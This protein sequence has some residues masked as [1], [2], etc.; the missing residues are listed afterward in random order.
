[1]MQNGKIMGAIGA[2]A[3]LAAAGTATAQTTCNRPI[4]PDVIVGDMQGI[5]NFTAGTGAY[6]GIDAFSL[7][8]YSCNV[9]NVWLNWFQFP[10]NQHPTIGGMLYRFDRFGNGVTQI[11]QIGQSWLKHGFFALSNNL[12]C[13]GCQSTDGTHL[14]VSCSDPYTAARNASQGGL[15][16]RY[17]VNAHTGFFPTGGPA[18]GTGGSGTVYRRNQFL[19]ADVTTSSGGTGAPVRFYGETQYIAADDAAAGNADNNSSYIELSVTGS[20]TDRTLARLGSTVR[21]KAAV[22]AWKVNDATVT[23][24]AADVP[25]EGHYIVCS[26]ATDIGGGWWHYEYV[27]H[28]MNSDR[29]SG[30]FSVPIS[31]GTC[32]QNIGFHDVAYR[33]GDGIGNVNQSGTD[34]TATVGS[35]AITWATETFAQNQNANAIRWSTSYNFRFDAKVAPGSGLMNATV[36]LFKPGTPSS[37]TAAVQY[38]GCPADWD[39]DGF[40]SGPDYDLFVQQFEAGDPDTDFDCDGFPTGVDFDVYVQSFEAGC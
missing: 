17:Q 3:L 29:S 12:C 8:T 5:S 14:G 39:G 13:A 33:D 11:Q 36:G 32:V 9:G 1:M 21:E 23:E 7:G 34:W 4:G 35:N 37:I 24:S 27:V 30:S 18:G 16:P 15:G 38:P 25:N 2:A 10:S 40:L 6:A 22:Q 26:D 31:P 19:L 28:N 20:A